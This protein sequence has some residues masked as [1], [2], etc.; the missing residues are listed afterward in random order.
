[1]S[2][3]VPS[4]DLPD[5][6]TVPADDLPSPQN[7]PVAYDAIGGKSVPVGSPEDLQA[8]SP[9]SGMSALQLA[10]AG[11][12]KSQFDIWNGVKQLFGIKGAQ[13]AVDNAQQLDRPLMQTTAA[14]L[15]YLGGNIADAVI[16]AGIAS[17]ASEAA[18]LP[19]VASALGGLANPA[20]FGSAA[21]SGAL[22]GLVQPVQHG[23]SR[24]WNTAAGAVGGTLGQGIARV[25][26]AATDA[27]TGALSE[28][29]NNAVRALQDAGVPLDAAQ[30]TGSI[31]LQRAKAMLSDNPLTAGA[32]KD[33]EDMQSKAVTKAFMQTIGENSAQAS[34]DVMG[35][36]MA[37][38]GNTYNDLY[39]RI[40]LPYDNVEEPLSGV[41]N[42]ARITLDDNQ[43]G[44][45]QR[46]ADDI[47]N[48][49]SR[50]GGVIG[51]EQFQNIK[52]TLDTLSGGSDSDV[53]H[54]ARDIREAMNDGLL[55]HAQQ[56]GNDADVQLLQRTNQQWRNMRTIEGAIDKQGNYTVSPARV[57]NI[58]GQK[59]NR[60]VSVYGK[61]DTTL[62]DLAQAANNL[63]PNKTPNSGTFAR[64]AASS[65]LPLA[66][67]GAEAVHSGDWKRGAELG[68]GAYALPKLFQYGMN[69]Q[70]PLATGMTD[71]IGALGR[72]PTLGDLLSGALQK[73]PA[74][75]LFSLE[76]SL[77]T[78]KKPKEAK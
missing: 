15:G 30:R 40:Q 70:A 78:S 34:P 32:Q 53:G 23:G 73:A 26:S 48:K 71:M 13:Q 31:L 64:L 50:N 7:P 59:A 49:A 14:K 4:D 55:S 2:D 43:F 74:S 67:G 21:A 10:L 29:A 54:Y 65:A 36:A 47:L 60:S 37:R 39:S 19:R 51:G 28:H 18:S 46:V 45:I 6:S 44:K 62:A 12:G 8:Q 61:G 63:L 41:L 16:P 1:M 17:D 25:G 35:R 75:S 77:D 57:A 33:F 42:D 68:V 22:Q 9:T 58:L 72:S 27:I 20:T 11:A 52:S 3:L 24:L 76:N 69:A 66:V 5:Q 38:L 56:T